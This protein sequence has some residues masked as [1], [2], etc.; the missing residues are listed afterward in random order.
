MHDDEYSA[1][2]EMKKKSPGEELFVTHCRAHKLAPEREYRFDEKR[3]FRFDFAFPAQ[4]FAI[5]IEGGHWSG[6]RHTTGV[7]FEKDIE[8]YELAMLN[9]WT[10]YR[11]TTTMVQSGRAIEVTLKMLELLRS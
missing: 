7:G 9:G 1:Q 4:K 10:V 3:R 5:E 8:K 11:C 2:R 6:G